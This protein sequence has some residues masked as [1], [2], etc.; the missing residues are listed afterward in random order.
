VLRRRLWL[1]LSDRLTSFEVEAGGDLRPVA[2][3]LCAGL[4]PGAVVA[5]DGPIGAGKTTLVQ[6]CAI[7]LGVTEPVTSPTFALAHRYTGRCDVSHLDLYR[8]EGQPL[9][10]TR[11]LVDYVTE[12]A[13]AF[14]EWPE[15]GHAWLPMATHNVAI[16]VDANGT[17]RFSIRRPHP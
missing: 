4:T 6:A 14:I 16:A 17:R 8:L 11:D 12:D 5:L 7:E 15:F 9:R 3:A 2:A 1:R 10:D 13:I